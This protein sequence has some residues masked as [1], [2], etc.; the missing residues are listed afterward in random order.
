MN[1]E[2]KPVLSDEYKKLKAS[3]DN[4]ILIL[5]DKTGKEIIKR[6]V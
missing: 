4:A 6:R 1:K 3:N 2:K 5:R